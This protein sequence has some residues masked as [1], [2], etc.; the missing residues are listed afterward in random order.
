[1]DEKFLPRNILA[2]LA[3]LGG[4]KFL[5]SENFQLYGIFNSSDVVVEKKILDEDT[6]FTQTTPI[7][8]T[9]YINFGTLHVN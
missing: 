7:L 9:N 8:H 2:I 1:M 6:N 5:S 4:A 3:W